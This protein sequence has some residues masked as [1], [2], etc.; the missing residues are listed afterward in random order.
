MQK[1]LP[2][3]F[4]YIF[5]GLWGK[6]ICILQFAW[7]AEARRNMAPHSDGKVGRMADVH[8]VG[9]SVWSKMRL[10]KEGH[11]SKGLLNHGKDLRLC[12]KGSDKSL[13]SCRLRKKNNLSWEAHSYYKEWIAV[14]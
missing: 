13:K 8:G 3:L 5:E 6:G 10:V 11:G 2:N 12:P 7:D 9:G 14:S 1:S 4:S